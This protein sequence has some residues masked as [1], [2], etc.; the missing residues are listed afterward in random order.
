MNIANDRVVSLNYTLTNAQNQVL[1]ST[2]P[3]PF[4]YLHGRQNIIPGLEKAL[5]GKNQ[6]DSLKVR[7]PAAEAYGERNDKL[8]ATVPLDRFSGA[9]TVKEG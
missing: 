3:E 5:D 7:V 8:I 2:G 6:G 9:D 4:L 1:D